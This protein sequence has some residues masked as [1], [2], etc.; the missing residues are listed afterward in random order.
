MGLLDNMRKKIGNKNLEKKMRLYKAVNKERPVI[1][2]VVTTFDKGG[3][4]Q[5]VLNLYSGYKKKG[6]TVFL[7]CQ[8]NILGIMAESIEKDN[9][10]VF[11]SDE[12]TFVELIAN[13]C[14][15]VLHYHYNVFMMK[16]MKSI[17]VKVIYTMHNVYTWKSSAEIRDY[18]TLLSSADC[19]IPV[20]DFVSDYF[21]SRSEYTSANI[22]VIY[23]GIRVE[24][25]V[26]NNENEMISRSALGILS[27]DIAIAFIAS[28]YPV[29]AQIGMIGVMEKI[30]SM[31]DDIK[32]L[33]VGNIGDPGYY[34]KFQELY[35]P[36]VAKES[37]VLVPYFD[38]KYMGY[39]LRNTCDIFIL[40]TLQE[41]CSNA[42]LEAIICDKPSIITNVGN[43]MQIINLSSCI[44]VPTAYDDLT[45]LENN[46]I[47]RISLEKNMQ[48]Q[49][50]I[51]NAIET[52]AN[53]IEDYKVNAK[54]SEEEKDKYSDEYMISEY[55]HV[56][57]SLFS[58]E[59]NAK[60]V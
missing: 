50:E 57:D 37:I 15:T 29:K 16:K 42:V 26:A 7:L 44:V 38:H 36:S 22:K 55:C 53:S 11:N 13:H 49:Q 25:L 3:L 6:Y 48:N 4:E 54:L 47:T 52:I 51:V 14:I 27:D 1:G 12:L 35:E 39:F 9:L 46:D 58:T 30:V 5:V 31:R 17:G 10:F 33:L 20:S 41:G 24:A 56:I 45:L 40:P 19:V 2:L 18:A 43:A 21:V 60:Y 32:L 8:E 23:N 28:F 59:R 34:E